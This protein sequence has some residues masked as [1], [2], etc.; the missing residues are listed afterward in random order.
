MY[1]LLQP[2][3]HH[4][5]TLPTF[6]FEEDCRSVAAAAAYSRRQ[7][8][9]YRQRLHRKREE[10]R[11]QRQLQQQQQQQQQQALRD[12][13]ENQIA[14]AAATE[15]YLIHQQQQQELAELER[16]RQLQVQLQLQR[17]ERER[18]IELQCQ[19]EK[20]ILL[21]M[22]RRQELERHQQQQKAKALAQLKR[23]RELKLNRERELEEQEMNLLRQKAYETVLA[24]YLHD[25]E[26]HELAQR[27]LKRRKLMEEQQQQHRQQLR[28]SVWGWWPYE[29]ELESE[30][31]DDEEEH[32]METQPANSFNIAFTQRPD[33]A[34]K[35][36]SY[37]ARQIHVESTNDNGSK[38][39]IETTNTTPTATFTTPATNLNDAA[40]KIQTWY[41]SLQSTRSK[42][43]KLAQLSTE[44]SHLLPS[45]ITDRLHHLESLTKSLEID[46]NTNSTTAAPRLSLGAKGN[47]AYLLLEEQL[48]KLLLAADSVESE[49]NQK[50]RDARRGLISEIQKRLD[51]LEKVKERAIWNVAAK[52]KSSEEAGSVE[53]ATLIVDGVEE[54][55]PEY[56]PTADE[57]LK[58]AIATAASQQQQPRDNTSETFSDDLIIEDAI[59][60]L[61]KPSDT[62]DSS[63]AYEQ[64][65]SSSLASTSTPTLSSE[66][67]PASSA[68]SLELSA[69]ESA[70]ESVSNTTHQQ[71]PDS[72]NW[73]HINLNVEASENIESTNPMVDAALKPTKED[74]EVTGTVTAMDHEDESEWIPHDREDIVD[75]DL[76]VVDISQLL[77]AEG[78]PETGLDEYSDQAVLME[79]EPLC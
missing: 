23:E 21:E 79:V 28:R 64:S 34:S 32:E 1:V 62:A 29:E 72:D 51:E 70:L 35:T 48:T 37:P 55:V 63:P 42:L 58:E 39:S 44:I 43:A 9:L 20:Q 8:Q 46:I 38:S 26:E 30:E 49:G 65:K 57:A 53:G 67:P 12:F 2:T 11:Q 73:T 3:I 16:Q 27:E 40:Q 77:E 18:Q 60:A 61:F 22:Q 25:L 10:E 15:F 13:Y 75:D 17:I 71:D 54:A 6:V 47:K 66:L 31:D 78:E 69:L 74:S 45:N 5:P 56:T 33:L 52:A 4:T 68:T 76:E 24:N 14:L 36:S 7:E 59:Q 50:V 19:R 41:R